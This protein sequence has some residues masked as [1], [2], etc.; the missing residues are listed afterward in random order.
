MAN[1]CVVR[2]ERRCRACIAEQADEILIH[3]GQSFVTSARAPLWPVHCVEKGAMAE[4]Y[5]LTLDVGVCV[6]ADCAPNARDPLLCHKLRAW[7]SM[8]NDRIAVRGRHP[9][10]TLEGH[11]RELLV[12]DRIG[13]LMRIGLQPASLSSV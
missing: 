12:P 11:G 9:R 13:D 7:R 1:L 2:L 8:K 6:R 3:R 10:M 5:H 4:D